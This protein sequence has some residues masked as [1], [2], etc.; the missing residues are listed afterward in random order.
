MAYQMVGENPW[1]Q[2]ALHGVYGYA[3]QEMSLRAQW[4]FDAYPP[5]TSPD[6]VVGFLVIQ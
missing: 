3:L 4:K 6:D 1:G 2:L 5:R